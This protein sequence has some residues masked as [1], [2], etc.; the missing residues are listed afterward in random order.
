SISA[1]RGFF[2]PASISTSR[3]CS[4]SC[5]TAEATALMPT[6]HWFCLDMWENWDC[7]WIRKAESGAALYGL[8]PELRR[9]VLLL[10]ALG[11]LAARRRRLHSALA[12]E[13]E[14]DLAL[15]QAGLEHDDAHAVAEPELAA[16]ALAGQGLA[17]RVEVVEVAWQL[18]HVDQAVD[19]G[20]VELDEQAEAGHAADRA[21]ELGAH[22][23]LHPR[24]AVALVHLAFGF[25]GT[26][27]ALGALQRQRRHLARAVEDL[28]APPR[29]HVLDRAMHQQVR[30]AP[31]R[32]GEMRVGLQCQAEMADVV[33]RIHRLALAAQDHGLE[34]GRVGPFA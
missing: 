4:A 33:G 20:L 15:L 13:A 21:V 1:R 18:G 3:T 22:M 12:G 6:I 34:Q 32:R 17:H 16:R 19:L 11:R 31:D 2:A 14:V 26:A 9:S 27:R 5:S 23:L 24:G 30:I 28:A 10:P 29:Q 7:G 8:A 25:L